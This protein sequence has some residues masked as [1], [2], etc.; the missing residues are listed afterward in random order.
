MSFKEQ[1]RDEILPKTVEYYNSGS[2]INSAIVKA[3]SDFKLNVDQTDRLVE[4]MNTARVI[5]HYEKNAEDR[6][7]NCDIADKDT[8]HRMLFE[9]KTEKKASFGEPVYDYDFYGTVERNYRSDG[10]MVKAAEEEKKPKAT[11]GYSRKQIVERVVKYASELETR[12]RFAEERVGMAQALIA[13]R[14]SKVARALSAGYEPEERYALFKVASTKFPNAV[15][16]I[17]KLVP[18]QI[19]KG[20]SAFARKYRRANVIDDSSVETMKRAAAQIEQ[21]ITNTEKLVDLAKTVARKEAEVK[22][23]VSDYAKIEKRAYPGDPWDPE[24][25][26]NKKKKDEGKKKDQEPK[27]D[28]WLASTAKNVESAGKIRKSVLSDTKDLHDRVVPTIPGEK[29]LYDYLTSSVISPENIDKAIFPERK[30]DT[31]LREYINNIRRS[32]ILSELAADDPILSEADP[33]ALAA[34]YEMLS[35][36]AP[37]AS[38]K[39]EVARAILRQSV[40][41]VAVSP[42]DTKQWADLDSVLLKNRAATA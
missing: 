7:A 29:A 3:A 24:T 4:T 19:V 32:S 30:K 9:D 39:K 25:D 13:T 15:R 1:L 18:S 11:D 6:T 8:V 14:L 31:S 10:T 21:D 20:A 22:K 38:L 5:A 12:R 28:P 16:E 41:S 36:A 26:P 27:K 42:F 40:N 33:K 37:E 35:N 34:A 23:L 17:E 2:D